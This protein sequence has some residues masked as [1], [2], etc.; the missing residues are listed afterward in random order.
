VSKHAAA[1][2]A[3][4]ALDARWAPLIERAWTG[5]RPPY[6][7]TPPHDV[8]ETLA[9]IRETVEGNHPCEGLEPSQG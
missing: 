7:T 6:M 5:R 4:A 1:Q 8:D 9:F 3:Q 2:W